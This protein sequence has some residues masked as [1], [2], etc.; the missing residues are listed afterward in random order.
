LFQGDERQKQIRPGLQI[1]SLD[2]LLQRFSMGQT[3]QRGYHHHADTYYNT[4]FLQ[5]KHDQIAFQQAW[6]LTVLFGGKPPSAIS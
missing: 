4:Q 2:R 1:I 3:K 5:L 6:C